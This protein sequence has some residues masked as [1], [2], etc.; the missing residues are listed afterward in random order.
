MMTWKIVPAWIVLIGGIFSA[1]TLG[2]D[3]ES[4][5]AIWAFTAAMMAGSALFQ[6]A[7]MRLMQRR[8]DLHDTHT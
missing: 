3:G 6:H 1:V 7:T 4:L 8:L 2:L 5:G